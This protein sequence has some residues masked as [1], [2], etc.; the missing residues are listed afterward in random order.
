MTVMV[1]VYTNLGGVHHIE[2]Y[3]ET[4]EGTFRRTNEQPIRILRENIIGISESR[5]QL[6][7]RQYDRENRI[8]LTPTILHQHRPYSFYQ[9]LR[10]QVQARKIYVFSKDSLSGRLSRLDLYELKL[11]SNISSQVLGLIIRKYTESVGLVMD[12]SE[13]L[14]EHEEVALSSVVA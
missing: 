4:S 3:R 10:N 7:T 11:K 1:P 12:T 8:W 5:G 6:V 13:L 9:F 2:L 14:K